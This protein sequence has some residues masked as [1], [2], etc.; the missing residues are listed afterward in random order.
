MMRRLR[1]LVI[2]SLLW[3]G[4]SAPAMDVPLAWQDSGYSLS[5]Y[6]DSRGQEIVFKKEPAYSG[7]RVLRGAL[8]VGKTRADSLPYAVDWDQRTLFLD[9]NRNLDLTDDLPLLAEQSN[10]YRLTFGRIALEPADASAFRY[11]VSLTFSRFSANPTMEVQSGWSGT[12]VRGTQTWEVV[13]AD[14]LDGEWGGHDLLALAPASAPFREDRGAKSLPPMQRLFFDGR[15]HEVSLTPGPEGTWVFSLQ[16]VA[17]PMGQLILDGALIQRLVLLGGEDGK[18]RVV[19]LEQPGVAPLSVPAETYSVQRITLAST[20]GRFE[21]VRRQDLVVREGQSVS[22]AIGGPLM[23]AATVR[24][25]G[26]SLAMNYTLKGRGGE[27]Y[28]AP[29]APPDSGNNLPRVAIFHGQRK[30]ASGRFE[31]G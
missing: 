9:R 15:Q 22:L 20:L 5:V 4:F 10:D 25:R 2:G 13:F 7:A 3:P 27:E 12:F 21:A 29:T 14:D 11:L 26:G 17:A 31:Y 16:E 23:N 6:Y 1:I 24:R 18:G 19:V 30:I 8:P 28:E